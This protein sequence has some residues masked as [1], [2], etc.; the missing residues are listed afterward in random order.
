MT[1][2]RCASFFFFLPVFVAEVILIGEKEKE[3]LHFFP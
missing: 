2:F 1:V 3:Y